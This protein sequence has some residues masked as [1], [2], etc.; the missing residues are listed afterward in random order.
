MLKKQPADTQLLAEIAGL[1]SKIMELELQ[2]QEVELQHRVEAETRR[3]LMTAL[4]R[5][6]GLDQALE[7][8]LHPDM[9]L[10]VFIL[11]RSG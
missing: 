8:L 9:V 2:L 4:T 7:I 3:D 11:P 10:S 6:S 5:S 1:R